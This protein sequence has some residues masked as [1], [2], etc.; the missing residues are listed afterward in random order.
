MALKIYTKTGDKGETALFG[1]KRLPKSHLRIDAYGTVDELN[2]YIGLVRDCTADE[3]MRALL[4]RIQDCL[5]V[6]GSHL[7]TDPEKPMSLPPL[8]D[9]DV[10]ALEKAI[11]AMNESLPT[12]K[13]FILPGGHTTVSF[14]HIARTVCR[15]AERLTVALALESEVDALLIRYLNRLSDYL[16]VL[17]RK[18][19]QDL[20]AEEVV[21]MPGK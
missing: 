11:D 7:A 21:W 3:T 1:G 12:L 13:H 16:F 18:L 4:K 10:E 17:S 8:H 20:G 15:R 14:C 5:F 6:L 9:S 19:G 2:S